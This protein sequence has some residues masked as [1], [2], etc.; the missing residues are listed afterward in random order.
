MRR[1]GGLSQ[2]EAAVF[3]K[4][5]LCA[6][7]VVGERRT[8]GTL[9][10][11]GMIVTRVIA[12]KPSVEGVQAVWLDTSVII[13][14][15]HFA[16]KKTVCKDDPRYRDL[17][18]LLIEKVA[19]GKI[20]CPKGDQCGEYQLGTDDVSWC[21]LVEAQL[22][23]DYA[24]ISSC[25]IYEAQLNAAIRSWAKGDT[26]C[27]MSYRDILNHHPSCIQSRFLCLLSI[28]ISE[29][30]RAQGLLE[31]EHILVELSDIAGDIKQRKVPFRQQLELEYR[32]DAKM[33]AE[34]YGIS[35]SESATLDPTVVIGN[36]L[37]AHRLLAIW[38]NAGGMPSGPEGLCSFMSSDEYRCLPFVHIRSSLLAAIAT[39]SCIQIGD[40]SDVSQLSG[41]LPYCDYVITDRKMKARLET[42]RL[43][44]FYGTKAR[45]IGDWPILRQEL[46]QS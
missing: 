9:Q 3:R 10:E 11:G 2:R 34:V 31:K 27:T 28:T 13:K 26:V 41:V 19:A 24:F 17:Y 15:A 37:W 44:D 18:E 36:R 23:G 40:A 8:D 45:C 1:E 38:E 25:R 46:E 14:F 33:L 43:A 5:R 16:M 20:A 12:T 4:L 7:A 30:D 29:C 6:W 21:R 35:N 39:E 32:A 42:T 22:S